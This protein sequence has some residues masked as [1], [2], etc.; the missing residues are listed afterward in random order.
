MQAATAGTV[1]RLTSIQAGYNSNKHHARSDWATDI[2]GAAAE[3]A[4]ARA[5]GAYWDAGN[6]TF[7]G[8]DVGNVQVR[9]TTV[10]NGKLIV[11][12]NDDPAAVFILV[13]GRVPDLT[14]R[15]WMSGKEAKQKK[16]K[17]GPLQ[18]FWWVPQQDLH[19]LSEPV[20]YE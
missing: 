3:L 7:K 13:T 12:P 15:G 20:H 4:V 10:D 1:R 11:R 16:Y 17:V 2:E 6:K 19:P 14:L 18:N 8:A 9:S 5:L